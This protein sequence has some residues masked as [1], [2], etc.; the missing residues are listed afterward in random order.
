MFGGDHRQDFAGNEKIN[1]FTINPK[2]EIRNP[3]QIQKTK[4]QKFKTFKNLN[5]DIVLNFDIRISNFN[6]IMPYIPSGGELLKPREI[7]EAA[8]L[9]EGMTAADMGC[10][11]QGHFVFAAA[12]IVGE[13]G[14]VYGV[15]ILKSALSGVES[16]AKLQ[17]AKNVETV[18]SDIE[19]YGATKIAD[20]SLDMVMLINNLPKE[21]ML[22][23]ATRLIKPGGRLLVVDWK[24]AAAPFGPPSKDRVSPETIKNIA[25]NFGLKLEKEWS[26]GEYHFA[27]TFFK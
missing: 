9:T 11:T 10:G 14:K 15:D 7:L 6:Q 4:I 1:N 13:R 27:L 17:N 3:K 19:V 12:R 25:A 26:A 23:E 20:A 22:R 21:A 18:W 5:L 16:Q 2:H 24:S 8:G